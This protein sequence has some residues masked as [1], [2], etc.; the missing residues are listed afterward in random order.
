MTQLRFDRCRALVT[1]G[2]SGIGKA[3]AGA[4]AKR[5]ARVGIL[6]RHASRLEEAARDIARAAGAQDRVEAFSVDVT[7]AAD[8]LAARDTVLDRLGGLDLLV[9]SAGIS[10][11][12]AVADTDL[13]TMRALMDVNYFGTVHVT[14]AFLPHLMAQRR[15]HVV[16]IASVA[17]F[18]G[19]YGYGGYAASKFAVSGFF[20]C[21]RQELLP[22]GV[23]VTVAFPG[24]T[25]TP[26]LHAENRIKPAAT[27]AIAGNVPV[28]QAEAVAEAILEGVERQRFRVVP[29]P[30]A[31]VTE[32][33]FRHAPWL[34]RW[35][36]DRDLRKHLG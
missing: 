15:G 2:S 26:Q 24:D 22:Y 33:A 36:M 32:L 23:G 8:V 17:G 9:N 34:V 3:L 18:L 5:G 13:A 12:A 19:L 35:V 10:H 16:G 31:R 30:H 4:L 7:N 25:D 6:A 28:M 1:G 11:P 29:G 27:R 14:K 20:E 21:L